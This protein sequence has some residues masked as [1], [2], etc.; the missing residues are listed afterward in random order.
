MKKFLQKPINT[1]LFSLLIVC[2]IL[3]TVPINLFD[4]EIVFSVNGVEF[5]EKAK[6]SLGKFIGLGLNK[7]EMQD[8]KSFHLVGMGYFLASLMI[9]AL[10]ALIAYRVWIGNQPKD[11][12]P[13]A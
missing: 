9:F 11:Q 1:Y 12:T 7:T 13:N 3:F 4:G 8:V 10:P 6:I 2:T 5:T